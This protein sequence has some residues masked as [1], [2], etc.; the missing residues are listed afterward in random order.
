MKRKRKRK[1]KRKKRSKRKDR[2]KKIKGGFGV[3]KRNLN[4][5]CRYNREENQN[6]LLL[7]NYAGLKKA[8]QQEDL[9]KYGM[10]RN[11]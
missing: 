10:R 9:M 1:G 2:C 3:C 7:A 11:K 4:Y 5:A 8:S 6:P